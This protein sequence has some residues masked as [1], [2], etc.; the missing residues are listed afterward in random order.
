MIVLADRVQETTTT[1]GTGTVDLD[2]AK[3][4]YFGFVAA[5]GDGAEVD[6]TI[7]GQAGGG[8]AGEVETGTGVV[9]DAATDTLSRVTVH[10]SSNA[11][12]LVNFSA[13]TKDV[14]LTIPAVRPVVN[15]DTYDPAA[16]AS[17]DIDIAGYES[18]KIVGYLEPAND[19]VNLQGRFSNDGGATFESGAA[20]YT[21]S[22][23]WSN[24]SA[25][26]T[27]TFDESDAFMRLSNQTGNDTAESV[28]FTCDIIA[29]ATASA[30]T[31]LFL[32]SMTQQQDATFYS[33]HAAGCVTT[34][35]VNDAVQ[36]YF[37]AG[38]IDAGHLAVYGYP[39]P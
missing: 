24:A 20:Y 7:V 38:N 3:T 28:R 35:E 8:A 1:T 27:K 4:G 11:G 12:A 16:A 21:W 37:S 33:A 18:V 25:G 22:Y 34:A 9:T 30:R 23:V 26:P 32:H 2:G 19:N 17:V 15:I 36:F 31:T 29:S 14:F 39:A 5:A 13:G 6:Y 10:S